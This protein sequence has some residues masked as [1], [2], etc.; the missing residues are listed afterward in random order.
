MSFCDPA[1][2]RLEELDRDRVKVPAEPADLPE[3]L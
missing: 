2:H 1:P 3:I